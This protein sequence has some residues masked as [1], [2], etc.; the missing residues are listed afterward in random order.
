MS[1]RAAP[2]A[3]ATLGLSVG[4]RPAILEVGRRYRIRAAWVAV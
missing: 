3:N 4:P 1:I 2:R